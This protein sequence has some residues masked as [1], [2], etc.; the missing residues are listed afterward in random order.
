MERHVSISDIHPGRFYHGRSEA[1]HVLAQSVAVAIERDA[2]LYINGDYSEEAWIIPRGEVDPVVYK[3]ESGIVGKHL[4]DYC[5][6]TRRPVKMLMG[7][8]EVASMHTEEHVQQ[9]FNDDGKHAIEF[10]V[11]QELLIQ[12]HTDVV[13]T[14]G[15]I[16]GDSAIV[17][18]HIL[19]AL[20]GESIPEQ[21]IEGI[22]VH[23]RD[24]IIAEERAH[25]EK[26]D[27]YGDWFFRFIKKR[28]WEEFFETQ[29]FPS[30]RNP[31]KELANWLHTSCGIM[32][33]D[34]PSASVKGQLQTAASLS[35]VLGGKVAMVGHDHVAG[36]FRRYVY[37][38]RTG[39]E[40][41]VCMLNTG[42]F[43]GKGSKKGA[44]YVDTKQHVAELLL[45]N[46][47]TEK[48]H[49]YDAEHYAE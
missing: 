13:I 27:A 45:Y 28:G 14:H 8:H 43:L 35:H 44:S 26:L 39:K 49:T 46:P 34:K 22:N 32:R 9:Q 29:V 5:L 17:R 40:A 6:H 48:L 33:S 1:E 7:N 36:F 15:H 23:D 31:K 10:D 37:D 11:R 2:D 24:A 16:L 20:R 21:I 41:K 18:N 42:N 25:F 3:E 30:I 4:A 12:P 19:S 38:P 47:R